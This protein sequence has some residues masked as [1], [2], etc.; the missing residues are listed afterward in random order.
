MFLIQATGK[1][2]SQYKGAPMP[3]SWESKVDTMVTINSLTGE[4]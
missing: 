2:L 3:P 1:I 4:E